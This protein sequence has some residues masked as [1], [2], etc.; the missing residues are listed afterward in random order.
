M[1]TTK[2]ITKF[3]GVSIFQ[4]AHSKWT[5]HFIMFSTLH[6]TSHKTPLLQTSRGPVRVAQAI[7]HCQSCR[8]RTF[9]QPPSPR[10]RPNWRQAGAVGICL[11][12]NDANWSCVRSVRATPAKDKD[13]RVIAIHPCN[14]MATGPRVRATE[15]IDRSHQIARPS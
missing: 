12:E 2:S 14:V 6:S 15:R 4:T 8:W 10:P 13:C 1:E 7:S 3:E 11:A 9:P 5:F